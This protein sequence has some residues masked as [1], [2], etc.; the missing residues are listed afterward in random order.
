MSTKQEK[1]EKMLEMQRRFIALDR[2]QGVGMDEY[3]LPDEGSD[4]NNYRQD[5]M[6]CAMEVV[7]LA[8]EEKGSKN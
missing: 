4:L 5:Y 2:E 7:K 6:D 8:H 1:I 3:F